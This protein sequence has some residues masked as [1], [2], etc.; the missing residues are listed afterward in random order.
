M[1]GNGPIIGV[2]LIWRGRVGIALPKY[3][4][5]PRATPGNTTSRTRVQLSEPGEN[6]SADSC[7]RVRLRRGCSA[8]SLLSWC[9]FP[10][11][12]FGRTVLR[13]FKARELP[14]AASHTTVLVHELGQVF[15]RDIVRVCVLQRQR[16][17]ASNFWVKDGQ[18]RGQND[19]NRMRTGTHTRLEKL[20]QLLRS[21]FRVP[22]FHP[23][24]VQRVDIN[25]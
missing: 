10:F 2:G 25:Q 11:L 14:C 21:R 8:K 12:F 6:G 1:P 5:S 24:P 4:S 3:A 16:P 23:S 22:V 15:R 19:S 9:N 18:R 7:R 13:P 20:D 17:F